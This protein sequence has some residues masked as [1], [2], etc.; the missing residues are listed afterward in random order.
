MFRSIRSVGKAKCDVRRGSS[1]VLFLY[2]LPMYLPS[3]IHLNHFNDSM[4]AIIK[5][6][7]HV[8]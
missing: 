5:T 7:T 3:K 8:T 1:N 2:V 4:Q 6:A